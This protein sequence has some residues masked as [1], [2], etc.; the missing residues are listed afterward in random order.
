[1][2]WGPKPFKAFN[3]WLEEPSLKEIMYE[4]FKKVGEN[5]NIQVTLKKLKQFL[6]EWSST[7]L[8]NIG[9]RIK[10]LE[11]KIEEEE[12]KISPIKDVD[13]LSKDLEHL[14]KLREASLRQKA[15][16]VWLLK[17]DKNTK[18]FH[19]VVQKRVH[20]NSIKK[21]FKDGKWLS[22]MKDIKAAFLI[23]L[24]T[25]STFRRKAISYH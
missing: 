10:D 8:G 9:K 16:V 3:H 15:K 19:Q 14:Y 21:I 13:M 22:S 5:S 12:Q 1:M 11:D 18:F 4:F 25:S 6:K 23:T 20:R 17:G 2:I 7:C 24:I